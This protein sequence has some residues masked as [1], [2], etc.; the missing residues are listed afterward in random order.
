M[1]KTFENAKDRDDGMKKL[2]F[3]LFISLILSLLLHALILYFFG[4]YVFK[5]LP[6]EENV[7]HRIV[8]VS[9]KLIPLE[10]LTK[11]E[12]ER[13]QDDE[14]KESNENE[15]QAGVEGGTGTGDPQGLY[16]NVTEMMREMF[17]SEDL[18]KP[19]PT[20][21]LRF[22]GV[23]VDKAV[24][25]P[26]LPQTVPSKVLA[27]APRP[28]VIEIKMESLPLSRQALPRA[29]VPAMERVDV[30]FKSLPS[31]LPHGELTSETGVSYNVGLSLG[32][33]PKFGV[34]GELGKDI[35][36]ELSEGADDDLLTGLAPL[37][38]KGALPPLTTTADKTLKADTDPMLPK[39]IALDNFVD[40]NVTVYRD[41]R[42]SGFFRASIKANS[43]S[44]AM[45]DIAKDTM[46][47]I[48]HSNS[49]STSKLSQFKSAS[50]E[51]LTYLNPN[52]RFNVV[53]FTSHAKS[54]F[55]RFVEANDENRKEAAEYIKRLMR[56]GLTDVFG[57]IGPFVQAGNGDLNRPMNIFVLTDGQSTIDVHMMGTTKV[58]NTENDEFL[59]AMVGV[60]PG[61]V[62]IYPFS[63][64]RN[65]NR[66]LLDFMGYLNRGHNY[67][68]DDL[69]DFRENLVR[70]ISN[71]TS[72]IV[73][74]MKYLAEGK[75]SRTIYPRDLPHLYRRETLELYG[76]FDSDDTELVLTLSGYDAKNQRRD[77]VFRRKYDECPEG[78]REIAQS[79]AAQ[80]ILHLRAAIILCT[81][82]AKKA[83]MEREFKR[84]ASDFG[85]IVAY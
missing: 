55:P 15:G 63:A 40:V 29:T 78:G 66:T 48:D 72:L 64:G 58:K 2:P 60:N 79:W 14:R 83:A 42:G 4:N 81:D 51:A 49:I 44:D 36:K 35:L 74:D 82:A 38:G 20:P 85:I 13:K 68:V 1:E 70:Y 22:E 56:R 33:R 59:R 23:S 67:H 52:D 3:Y 34:P 80:K 61:N 19:P 26:Q 50:I 30:S 37:P 10:E 43:R 12:I 21:E 41:R 71:Y 28:Q 8:K 24:L 31:L 69:K 18:I 53:S 7:P 54:A 84:L 17:K 46:I 77:L 6:L 76:Q 11:R 62:S 9:T 25:Q 45:G 32:T 16:S 47:I 65:A 73:R 5:S 75:V 27:T 57:G 39:V